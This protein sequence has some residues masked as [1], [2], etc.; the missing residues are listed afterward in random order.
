MGR[1][2]SVPASEVQNQ[3]YGNN[4]PTTFN[5]PVIGIDRNG[6]ITSNTDSIISPEQIQIIPGALEAIRQ[7]KLKGYKVVLFFNE[8]AIT[9][10]NISPDMIDIV[11]NEL[12]KI[13]GQA[14]I[15]IGRAH[16]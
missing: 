2:T 15:K 10:S 3:N 11:N 8:P 14:G 7:I 16:V 1:Y 5:K 13:F 9:Q 6:V 4:W 12:M